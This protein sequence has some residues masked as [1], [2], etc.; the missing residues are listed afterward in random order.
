MNLDTVVRK[1]LVVMDSD[2]FDPDPFILW[3]RKNAIF[4]VPFLSVRGSNMM[5]QS[6]LAREY[7]SVN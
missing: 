5:C 1:R 2:G 4:E 3:A 7:A 6:V